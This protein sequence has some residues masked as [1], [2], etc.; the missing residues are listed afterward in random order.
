MLNGTISIN[1]CLNKI[2]I[3]SSLHE[4]VKMLFLLYNATFQSSAA[5]EHLFIVVKATWLTKHSMIDYCCLNRIKLVNSCA[6]RC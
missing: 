6:R 4:V 1:I 5:V 2:V 3:I